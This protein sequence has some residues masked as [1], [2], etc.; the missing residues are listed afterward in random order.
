MSVL[1][2]S[3]GFL[4]ESD[5]DDSNAAVLGTARFAPVALPVVV[6]CRRIFLVC[7]PK[8]LAQRQLDVRALRLL[9]RSPSFAVT[10]DILDLNLMQP[11]PDVAS[12]LAR[13]CCLRSISICFLG[14]EHDAAAC[15]EILD[16]LTREPRRQT[17]QVLA[18][19][20][21]LLDDKAIRVAQFI[22]SLS[23]LVELRINACEFS[24]SVDD[25]LVDALFE[26]D[27]KTPKLRRL[28]V[29]LLRC[30]DLAAKSRLLAALAESHY[31]E[32][33]RLLSIEDCDELSDLSPLRK[34][35]R[36]E[37]L[38]VK[39]VAASTAAAESLPLSFADLRQLKCLRMP[40]LG[41]RLKWPENDDDDGLLLFASKLEVLETDW[42]PNGDDDGG[43]H[44]AATQ[45]AQ[46]RLTKFLAAAT[47]LREVS[48][49]G[50]CDMVEDFSALAVAAATLE[51]LD[52][53]QTYVSP[54]SLSLVMSR[55]A[56]G[57]CKLRLLDVSRCEL[58]DATLHS[59]L[60]AVAKVRSLRVLRLNE[61]D[62]VKRSTEKLFKHCFGALGASLEELSCA[63]MSLDVQDE[64]AEFTADSAL[65][66]FAACL[67]QLRAFD[68]SGNAT[69]DEQCLRRLETLPA[70]RRLDFSGCSA[71]ESSIS[72]DFW[73]RIAA[74][75]TLFPCL[76]ELRGSVLG[77][78]ET[79]Q[80][81]QQLKLSRPHLHVAVSIQESG[82][83]EEDDCGD[84]DN[85]A[86]G[87]NYSDDDDNE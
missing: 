66:I 53:A 84:D 33:L 32:T 10:R 39:G 11:H 8:L 17:L 16:A 76:D 56:E 70:L 75:R 65:K 45:Q 25:V 19:E 1:S 37:S 41:A 63:T 9:A 22:G 71:A 38:T 20:S 7:A 21:C 80:A 81:L 13:C 3:F 64:S 55:V 83:E 57:P 26:A 61:L 49:R 31:A 73:S 42:V 82:E 12:L 40:N 48:L 54:A 60:P 14:T 23:S 58:L 35:Q 24:A 5:D 50:C 67:P 85:D 2:R 34:M 51:S 6:C 79:E 47:R 46:Q 69:V 78:A 43:T 62:I 29:L 4:V 74:Q 27:A 68:C 28:E 72:S 44:H 30:V 18:L 86:P 15:N 87:Y 36:L 52:L 59:W 77:G